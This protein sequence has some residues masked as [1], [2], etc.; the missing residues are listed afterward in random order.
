MNQELQ[1]LVEG[2]A[3]SKY[4][5]RCILSDFSGFHEDSRPEEIRDALK[6]FAALAVHQDPLSQEVLKQL[7]A[8]RLTEQLGFESP[9]ALL[10]TAFKEAENELP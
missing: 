9:E 7:A 4:P 6:L 2:I 5:L 1:E 8:R 10:N 3:E